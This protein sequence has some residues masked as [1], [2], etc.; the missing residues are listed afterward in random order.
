MN[1]N[2]N[3]SSFRISFDFLV[4]KFPKTTTQPDKQKKDLFYFC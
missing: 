2:K 4:K 3:R 1:F